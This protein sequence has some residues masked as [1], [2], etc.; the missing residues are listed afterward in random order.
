MDGSSHCL[1]QERA[2]RSEFAKRVV[3][4]FDAGQALASSGPGELDRPRGEDVTDAHH[5]HVVK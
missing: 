3:D 4:N 5:R 1:C 2:G